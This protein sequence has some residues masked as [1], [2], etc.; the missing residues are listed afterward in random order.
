M[1]LIPAMLGLLLAIG[2]FIFLITPQVAH[3]SCNA[4]QHEVCFSNNCAKTSLFEQETYSCVCM[5]NE[6]DVDSL[7]HYSCNNGTEGWL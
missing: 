5:D 7:Y 3:A 2:V 4:N 1:R 6:C